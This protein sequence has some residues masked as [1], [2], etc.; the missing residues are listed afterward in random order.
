MNIPELGA[1]GGDAVVRSRNI[2]GSEKIEDKAKVSETIE[3]ARL[4]SGQT[5]EASEAAPRDIFRAS[6]DRRL[7]EDWAKAVE[8]VDESTRRDILDKA[9]ERAV[10]GY[11]NNDEFLGGLALRLVSAALNG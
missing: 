8:D 6:E 10:S 3:N 9:R 5:E 11:Y 7:I 4:I 1:T 2:H